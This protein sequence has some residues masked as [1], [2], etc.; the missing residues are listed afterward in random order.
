[1]VRAGHR[2]FKIYLDADTRYSRVSIDTDTR[3]FMQIIYTGWSD[4]V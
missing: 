3:Y 4:Q 1:M 2:Y